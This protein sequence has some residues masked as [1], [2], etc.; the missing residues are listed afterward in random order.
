MNELKFHKFD[1]TYIDNVS[2]YVDKWVKE[3]PHCSVTIG[4]D[5]QKHSRHIQYA[6]SIVMHN[7]DEYGIG[8]GAHCIYATVIDKNKQLKKDIYT[9][10]WGEVVI[11]VEAAK[12]IEKCGKKITI[13]LDYNSDESYMSNVLYSSGIGYAS[14]FG[15]KAYGKP[16]AFCAS[17]VSDKLCR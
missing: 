2:E 17:I 12:I 1:G 14:S 11:A 13:H 15:F 6:V 8:K 5:S 10:L 16:D 3:H 4:C 9:K 7:V